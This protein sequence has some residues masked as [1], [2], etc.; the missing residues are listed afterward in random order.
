MSSRKSKKILNSKDQY[1]IVLSSNNRI[2]SR[3]SKKTFDN[4]YKDDYPLFT[5][6]NN[7]TTKTLYLFNQDNLFMKFDNS[8]STIDND[9]NDNLLL[10]IN[11]EKINLKEIIKNTEYGIY[12]KND[13]K[14]T[15]K[16][17][18]IIKRGGTIT[19][20]RYDDVLF[21]LPTY[22]N[23]IADFFNNM[24]I[25]DATN[26]NLIP[27]YFKDGNIASNKFLKENKKIKE[28]Q[29]ASVSDFNDMIVTNKYNINSYE[30]IAR[31]INSN[32]ILYE[33]EY[34]FIVNNYIGQ[35][36]SIVGHTANPTYTITKKILNYK[37]NNNYIYGFEKLFYDNYSNYKKF[38]DAQ[39]VFLRSLRYHEFETIRDY[40]RPFVFEK[41]IT[42]IKKGQRFNKNS[43]TDPLW[44]NIGNSFT[45]Y[46]KDVITINRSTLLTEFNSENG[47]AANTQHFN[48]QITD[49]INVINNIPNSNYC[50][51]LY[52]LLP[53]TVW[54]S[55][56]KSLLINLNK[57]IEKAPS[58]KD[59][60]VLYR[61]SG[62]NYMNIPGYEA[63]SEYRTTQLSSFSYNFNAAYYFYHYVNGGY[64][65]PNA[66]IYKLYLH[67]GVKVLL[68]TP[69]VS[70]NLKNE[71]EIL[72]KQ[73]QLLT[74]NSDIAT[75]HD[76]WNSIDMANNIHLSDQNK[77]KTIPIIEAIPEKNK[78]FSKL[79]STI[80]SF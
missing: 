19:D 59:P 76:C 62:T 14:Q 43:L 49:F 32:S 63:A 17:F 51:P 72:L 64:A 16:N 47:A 74:F 61:G 33:D 1:S 20:D 38:L 4:K 23:E 41:F 54:T 29:S 31:Y 3:K 15:L 18:G 53:N 67:K 24:D 6:A 42:P 65:N 69:F 12:I 39:D 37:Y 21:T 79:T 40:T 27:Y 77:F 7:I 34:T 55:I 36:G 80:A 68:T 78:L 13:E 44:V 22:N 58:V 46:I 52:K 2:T 35:G 75:T 70:D 66:V 25:L 28:I 8:V 26:Y 60:I 9:I 5:N 56:I 10:K 71:A 45:Q 73:G 30:N 57:I 48:D 11:E 50:H